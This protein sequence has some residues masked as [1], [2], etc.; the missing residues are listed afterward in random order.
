MKAPVPITQHQPLP[1]H[2]PSYF[3]YAPYSPLDYSNP[4]LLSQHVS[5]Q[6]DTR[7]PKGLCSLLCVPHIFTWKPSRCQTNPETYL[8]PTAGTFSLKTEDGV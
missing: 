3:I 7:L 6:H 5:N 1:A 4:M 2:G 8:H